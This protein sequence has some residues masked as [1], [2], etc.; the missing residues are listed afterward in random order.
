[1][2]KTQLFLLCEDEVDLSVSASEALDLVEADFLDW[3]N[4]MEMVDN[5]Q[6]YWYE[7]NVLG[8]S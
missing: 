1:M 3:C 5:Q 4:W 6:A 8:I 2:S 7:R